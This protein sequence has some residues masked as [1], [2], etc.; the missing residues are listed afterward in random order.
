M[1]L[2]VSDKLLFLLFPKLPHQGQVH[3]GPRSPAFVEGS[4]QENLEG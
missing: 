4:P 2:A 1:G 3:P